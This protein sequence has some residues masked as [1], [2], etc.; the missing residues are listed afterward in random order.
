MY[1]IYISSSFAFFFFFFFFMKLGLRFK[2][3]LSGLRGVRRVGA[4]L[5][6]SLA[7]FWW[8]FMCSAR[9][10][11]REKLRWHTMHWNGLAPVCFL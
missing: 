3:W 7:Q 6:H 11:E 9:W 5:N 10:S 8:R 2:G 4:A 1:K